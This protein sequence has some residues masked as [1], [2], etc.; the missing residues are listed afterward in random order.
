[1][2]RERLTGEGTYQM[3]AQWIENRIKKLNISD[4]LK[5]RIKQNYTPVLARVTEKGTITYSK[6]VHNPGAKP[7]IPRGRASIVPGINGG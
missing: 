2:K 5:G 7:S 1:L 3:D 6:I 4:E